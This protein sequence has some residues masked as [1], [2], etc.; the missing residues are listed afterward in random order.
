MAFILVLLM[1][2]NSSRSQLFSQA[3]DQWKY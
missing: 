1:N 2:S 3:V